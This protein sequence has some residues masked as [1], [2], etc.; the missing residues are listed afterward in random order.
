[1][2]SK[3]YLTSLE[4]ATYKDLYTH[5]EISLTMNV[6]MVERWLRNVHRA[7]PLSSI[8]TYKGIIFSYI[9]WNCIVLICFIGGIVFSFTTVWWAFIAGFILG[10]WIKSNV[11]YTFVQNMAAAMAADSEFYYSVRENTFITYTYKQKGRL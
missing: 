6:Y 3:F 5:D 2:P 9:I 11:D 8:M 4:Y 10:M 7:F 1:M